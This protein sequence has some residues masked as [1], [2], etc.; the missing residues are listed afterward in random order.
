M[1]IVFMGTPDFAVPVLEALVAAGHEIVLAVTQPDKA[2]GRSKA[3]VPPP[4]KVC[5]LAH[6]IPVFQPERIRR[7]EA[8]AEMEKIQADL[9]V[10]VAFGQILPQALLDLPKHGCFNVHASLLPMYRGA[11]PINHVI[12]AG[13]KESGVT[14]MQMDAGIDT[15]DILLQEAVPLAEDE[16]AETLAEK[17]SA[18]GARLIVRAIEELED[19]TLT[20][21]PQE[22]ETCYAGMLKKEMG[23]IDWK[24]PAEEIGRQVRGLLPWPGT[25][26]FREGKK[27]IIGA[28]KAEKQEVPPNLAAG[29]VLRADKSGLLVQTGEGALR[30]LQIQPEGKKMMDA[31]AFLNGSRVSEGELWG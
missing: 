22:G 14:I 4:V 27:L 24:K 15:G 6:G 26:T 3:P 25:Y 23:L 10:V 12:L 31:K 1:K 11:S 2:V 13:E 29:A 30:I 7:P 16:T 5:A 20:R 17:L 19:G 18:L 9:G 8:M 21:V 28:V